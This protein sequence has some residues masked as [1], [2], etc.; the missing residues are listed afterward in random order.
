MIYFSFITLSLLWGTSF[1][2]IKNALFVF[3]TIEILALRW[4]LSFLLFTVLILAKVIKVDYRNKPIKL[5]LLLV[6]C[7]PCLY[8]LF[9]TIGVD[10][11]TS[12]E[13]SIFIGIIPIMIVLEGWLFFKNKVTKKIIFA[14]C[15][16]F[17]GLLTCVIFSPEFS[18]GGKIFGYLSLLFAVTMGGLYS[19]ITSRLT[20]FFSFFEITFAMALGGALWFNL[21]SL[22]QGNGIAL[23]MQ[24]ISSGSTSL[25][26]LYLGIGCSF[27]AYIL[28][29]FTLTKL[30]A[31][32]ASC[33]QTN[34]IT[35]VGVIA[36]IIVDGDTW[37]RYTIIGL[38]LIVLGIY[39]SSKE[40]QH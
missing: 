3:S 26:I 39:I 2:F 11:T 8:A 14:I 5:L 7:Q 34:L 12:S 13:S 31:A 38:F 24:F 29:N 1:I 33:L 36:G 15:I 40:I 28:Y 4:T 35:I 23:Y 18:F 19:L 16:A 6:I 21:L 20:K 17:V 22:L 9:E 37:G 25:A 27:G 10:L 32:T 30:T